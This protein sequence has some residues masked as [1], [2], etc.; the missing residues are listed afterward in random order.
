MREGLCVASSLAVWL[1]A[2]HHGGL[3]LS[4]SGQPAFGSCVVI[5]V[6]AVVVIVVVRASL[7]VLVVVVLILAVKAAPPKAAFRCFD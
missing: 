4:N 3:A 7:V 6:V 1:E 5:L 2:E